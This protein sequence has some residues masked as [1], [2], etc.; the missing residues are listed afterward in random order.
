MDP[1]FRP[2]LISTALVVLLNTVFILPIQ[3]APLFTYFIGGLVAV[4]L[5]KKE[6]KDQFQEIKAGDA[7]ILGLGTGIVVGA[8]LTLI[9]AIKLQDVDMQKFVID[10]VNE[11]MKMH[12]QAEFQMLEAIGPGFYIVT[13]IIT[14]VICSMVSLFGG[15]AVL[16]FINKGKK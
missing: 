3:G 4:L 11:A 2:I 7:T 14:I 6:L 13:A 10:S 9:V 16:P 1:Y 15:L 12:S 5:F 8:I